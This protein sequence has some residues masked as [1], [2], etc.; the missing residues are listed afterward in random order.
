MF[1]R[2]Q[3][4]N[5]TDVTNVTNVT[6]LTRAADDTPT[7][8]T[9]NDVID[10]YLKEK[11]NKHADRVCKHPDSL[12]YTLKIVRD[13]WGGMTVVDFNIKSKARAK[14]KVEEWREA[15]VKT[16][17]CRKRI[18]VLKTAFRYCVDEELI[19]KDM[20]P[21]LKLPPQGPPRERVLDDKE[22]IALLAELDKP[23]TPRHVRLYIHLSLRT[24]QRQGAILALRYSEHIDFEKKVIRFRDTEAA[25]QRSK[26]RRTDIPMDAFLLDLLT[27]AHED[28]D[29]DAVIAF[30]DKP[31]R[32]ILVGVKAAYRRAGITANLTCHDLRRSAAT[33]VHRA[34]GGDL[35]AA[36]SFIGDTEAV[37][38]RHYV[39]DGAETRLPQV[40]AIARM[41][42][43]RK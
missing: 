39:Q 5:L 34:M 13:C 33:L 11:N 27:R 35:K 17:T 8:H 18:A 36:A 22:I 32:S 12:A 30:N 10:E 41:L 28:S 40:E 3:V 6:N 38:A 4:T 25:D 31:V 15:G 1:G 23:R 24:G 2:A 37:A 14:A 7:L 29:C 20:M 42:D 16:A 26:K 9:V 19:P 21:L 43:A